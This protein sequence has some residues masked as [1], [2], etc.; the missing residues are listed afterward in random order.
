MG[1]EGCG[2]PIEAII[3][4]IKEQKACH[5]GRKGRIWIWSRKNAAAPP[6]APWRCS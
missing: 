5:A 2:S 1:S 4:A 6:D 3:E